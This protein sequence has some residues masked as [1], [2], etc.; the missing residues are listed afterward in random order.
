MIDGLFKRHI[1]PLWEGLARPVARVMTANQVTLAGLLLVALLSLAFVYHGSTL[2]FGI[3]LLFAFSA[4]SLDG[5]VARLRG[6]SSHF[7][8]YLDAMVDRYQELFVLAAVAQTTGHWAAAFAVLSGAYLTSYAK[9]RTAIEMP[10]SNTDWPDLFERQERIIFLCLLLIV[11]GV[12]GARIDPY[13][14]F[15]G[16]GLWL[17]AVLC[18]VTALQRFWRARGLLKR[19]NAARRGDG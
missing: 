1:D 10:V 2:W 11:N 17:M 6:E 9:A 4:D 3:T 12:A 18:H 8:G 13:V 5:A 19:F 16:A 14:D 7:G 15:M